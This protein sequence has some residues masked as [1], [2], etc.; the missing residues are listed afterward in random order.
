[1]KR[2]QELHSKFFNED[3]RA[4]KDKLRR[5]LDALEWNFMEATLREQGREAALAE[6]K[7]ASATHRK[8]FF[9]WRLHFGEVFLQNA[10]ASMSSSP[11]RLTSGMRRSRHSRPHSSG[12]LHVSP[13]RPTCL[14]ISTNAQSNLLR[15]SGAL[16]LIT[17]NKYYR[18]DY[19]EKLRGFLTREL[20]LHQL[21][22]FGDAP[23]FEA[24]A[25]AS[26][27]TGTRIAPD[28]GCRRA[29]LHLGKGCAF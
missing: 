3:S 24:I 15:Y 7:R 29:W 14:Y 19:G 5:E 6:L 11:I 4:E 27:L 16:A 13:A 28:E 20:T 17:S 26:I 23:V 22:D 21:I 10:A 12:L 2:I 1:L 18:A 8:P 25:Y 9:L